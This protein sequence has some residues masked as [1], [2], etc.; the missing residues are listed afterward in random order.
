MHKWRSITGKSQRLRSNGYSRFILLKDA[1]YTTVDKEIH[2]VR[3]TLQDKGKIKKCFRRF[4]AMLYDVQKFDS[5]TE[6]TFALILS[7]SQKWFKPVSGQFQIFT[8]TASING[9]TSQIL[10]RSPDG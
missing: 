5:D 10:L 4:Q 7:E 9:S 1:A 6:R 8:K 2:N 3:I